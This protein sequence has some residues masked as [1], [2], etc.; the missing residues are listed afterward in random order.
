MTEEDRQGLQNEIDILRQVD[1]PNVVQL[2]D[3]YEDKGHFYLIMDLMTG[4]EVSPK[5][6]VFFVRQKLYVTSFVC[7]INL[8]NV[9][10][11]S[12]RS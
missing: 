6:Y 1:H 5:H 7:S 8:I 11:S 9:F 10:S 12:T 3:V 2:Y 4:G